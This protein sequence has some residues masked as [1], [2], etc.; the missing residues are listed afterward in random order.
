MMQNSGRPPH[1]REAW[2][3]Q[4]SD[5]HHL[6]P[7]PL[8]STVC[9]MCLSSGNNQTNSDCDNILQDKCFGI[10]QNVSAMKNKKKE[11]Q[12]HCSK[13]KETKKTKYNGWLLNSGSGERVIKD[14]IRIIGGIWISLE[15]YHLS[16][17]IMVLSII[18]ETILGRE[19][20][21]KYLRLQVHELY[22]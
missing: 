3:N 15:Y 7:Q 5:K 11:K 10:C 14:I 17:G 6:S 22:N 20:Y 12:D 1:P 9:Q 19:R 4:W 21:I 13:L 18:W 16:V 8:G 2:H